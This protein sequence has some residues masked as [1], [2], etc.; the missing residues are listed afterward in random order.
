MTTWTRYKDD[1]GPRVALDFPY[2]PQAK[3]ELKAALPFPRCKWDAERKSWSVKDNATD[4]TIALSVLEEFGFYFD[5]DVNANQKGAAGEIIIVKKGAG[6]LMSWPFRSDYAD[7]NAVIKTAGNG[8]WKKETKQWRIPIAN[9]A[10]V[11]KGLKAIY[12]ELADAILNTEGVQEQG[13]ATA[14]RVELSS[15]V[16]APALWL[17]GIKSAELIRPYQWVAPNMFMAGGQKRILIADGMGLGKSLQAMLCSVAGGFSKTLIICPAVV[18]ANWAK[19]VKKWT[20]STV[21]IISGRNGEYDVSDFTVINYDILTSRLDT[22]LNDRYDCIIIDE[23]HNLK[24]EKTKKSIATRTLASEACVNGIICLSGTPILNRPIEAFPVLNMLKPSHFDNRYHFGKKYCAAIHNGF[25][26]DFNGASNIE[27]SEDGQTMPLKQLLMDTMLRRTMDDERL[28]GQM[29]SLIQN[30]I[31]VESA[32]NHYEIT[33]QHL[34]NEWDHY[35]TVE[36]GMPPGFVLNMLTELRHAAGLS[37]ADAAVEWASQ[38]LKQTGKSLVIFAHHRDV[39]DAIWESLSL[40]HPSTRLIT[41]DTSMKDREEH[42]LHFQQGSVDF[43]I[44]STTAMRE[45]VN[46]DHADTTLFVERQWVPAWEQQA[47]A[48]VRRM[49]QESSVCQQVILSLKDSID[50]HFD[51]LLSQKESIIKA[52]LDGTAND[53]QTIAKHLAKELR[54]GKKVME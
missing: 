26:W 13:E 21:S 52:A 18:K 17:P 45:G 25:A 30:I 16:D 36:G 3:D 24:D 42:I 7:I 48:R 41:G 5:L 53:K 28:S 10:A 35:R 23:C 50:T 34:M 12:S 40:L 15:A 8:R 46:L 22:L 49:T 29:P 2:D 9:A 33:Y 43:L 20:N 39:L 47:A 32:D 54:A 27:H 14:K 44:C 1:Y 51:T 6:L 38:Y 4:L 37:K 31:E 19:E 11:A